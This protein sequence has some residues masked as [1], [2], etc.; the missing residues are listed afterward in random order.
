MVSAW[1]LE[2]SER[3]TFTVVLL[4]ETPLV[5]AVVVAGGRSGRGRL[6][7]EEEDRRLKE[8]K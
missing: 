3:R 4:Q 6:D 2:E 7:D 5:N 1:R 8:V